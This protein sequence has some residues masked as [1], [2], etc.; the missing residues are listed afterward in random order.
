MSFK[1]YIVLIFLFSA[2]SSQAQ[3]EIKAMSYNIRLDIASDGENRWDI[4][5]DKV[6]GLMNYYEADF[7]GMQEVLLNQLKYLQEHLSGYDYIGVGRDD[8]KEVGEFSCIFFKND[9]FELIRQNTFW[10]S[11]TPDSVSKG[12]DAAIKRICTYGLFKSKKTKQLFWVFNTHF[13]HIGKTARLE[14]AKLIIERIQELNTKNYPV[15]LM[16]DFN[17]RPDEPPAQ[18]I[19]ANMENSRSISK[20]IHGPADTWNAFKFHEKPSGCID[21]VFVSKDKKISVSK[22]ITITDSY[23][24]K[25][26]S[27]HLPV[28]ATVL[29]NK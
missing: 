15:I 21:Y 22:F 29:I 8:G 1:K 13:D 18:Y 10:L 27:D 23:D 16:G 12:W 11:P 3:T 14:S 26:P 19:M 20:M 28:M 9:K 7:I 17:S 4:R 5:K 2:L 25:Y 24:L 6:A